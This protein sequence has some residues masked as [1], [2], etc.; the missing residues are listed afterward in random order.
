MNKTRI[1]LASLLKPVN[2]TRM[3]EKLGV[4]ISKLPNVEVHISGFKA[5]LPSNF[6]NIFFHQ[7]FFFRRLSFFRITAQFK[8]LQLLFT[9]KPQVIIVGTHEL[10]VSSLFYKLLNSCILIYDVQENYYLNL[11]TQKIYSPIIRYV[12]AV[13]I[14]GIEKL[15]SPFIHTFFLA[16]E[17]YS[18]ELSFTR[19]KFLI[20][21]NKYIPAS[22]DLL[23]YT[24]SG[25]H[26]PPTGHIKLLYSGTISDLYG[27]FEAI[28]LVEA[29]H[30]SNPRYLLTIIGYWPQKSI[31]Q[32][33][34]QL[35][36]NKP[37]ITILGG[38]TIV[39]HS[40]IVQEIISS[41]VGLLPYH[42]HTSLINCLP[43]KLFEYLAHQ[44]PLI[45][46]NNPIW[47][48]MVDQYQAGISINFM[49]PDPH[50]ISQVLEK[51]IFYRPAPQE[52]VLWKAEEEKLLPYFKTILNS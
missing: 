47:N 51:K 6:V 1:L 52:E 50:A 4:S 43:T 24:N 48:K 29:L 8:F 38:D 3:F 32:K 13:L 7:I 17:S 27:I 14:R 46:Q 22:S 34:K 11:T 18:Q 28:K 23:P 10:L 2:D 40:Q 25:I 5:P 44:L 36:R 49:N 30:Q 31:G 21:Q 35:I 15:A 33:V 9:L 26:L 45:V 16:E 39:P 37:Y 12:A 41:H 19:D 20:L 42:L